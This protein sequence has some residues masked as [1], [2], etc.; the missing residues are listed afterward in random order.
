MDHG[1]LTGTCMLML[2]DLSSIL[3]L[4]QMLRRLRCVESRVSVNVLDFLTYLSFLQLDHHKL[5]RALRPI[6]D[7]L[8]TFR[9]IRV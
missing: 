1:C 5:G 3:E 6:N 4:L 9:I 7:A 2:G 8:H